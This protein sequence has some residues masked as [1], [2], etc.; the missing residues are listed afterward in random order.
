MKIMKTVFVT[1]LFLLSTQTTFS[2]NMDIQLLRNIHIGRNQNLDKPFTFLTDTDR[3]ISL[4]VPTT[5][6]VIGFLEKDSL[7]KQKALMI[8]GSLAL[9]TLFTL[10]LKN[11]IN[12]TR[13]F[14]KYADIENI[15]EEENPSSSFPS[16]HTSIAFSTATSLSISYPKWYVIGPS[17]L[18]ASGISY[19]RIHLGVHYPSDVLIGAVIG[20]GSAWLSHFLTKKIQ[21]FRRKY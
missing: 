3:G 19:S 12:R 10:S 9:T 13:P 4:L 7:T 2:Q 20:S 1:I 21:K 8:G 5:I 11:S 6:F 18:W 16:G 17:F 14:N 15:L